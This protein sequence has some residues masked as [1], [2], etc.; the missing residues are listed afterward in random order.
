MNTGYLATGTGPRLT[1]VRDT[2]QSV[3]APNQGTLL[4]AL[5]KMALV[6]MAW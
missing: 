4:V 5:P 3:I 2:R 1:I 6:V